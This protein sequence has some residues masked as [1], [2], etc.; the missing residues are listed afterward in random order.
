[1]H[2]LKKLLL[3]AAFLAFVAC[4]GST[5]SAVPTETADNPPPPVNRR[6]DQIP[7]P[8]GDK[9]P[10]PPPPGDN[11]PPNGG[12][13]SGSSGGGGGPGAPVPE[14]GTMVLVGSGLAGLAMYRRRQRR[15]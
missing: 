15:R 3:P 8:S 12:G 5:G 7:V 14:P 9:E 1:M 6:D 11:P 2:T 13:G 10:P 4:D